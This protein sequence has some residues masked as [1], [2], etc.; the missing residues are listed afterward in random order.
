MCSCRYTCLSVCTWINMF[1]QFPLY[2]LSW[3][4]HAYCASW[5]ENMY[6]H[7]LLN[8][9][10]CVY[11]SR[12]KY[13][14]VLQL[15]TFTFIYSVVTVSASVIIGILSSFS[16]YWVAVRGLSDSGSKSPLSLGVSK[17]CKSS[18]FQVNQFLIPPLA[19][20]FAFLNISSTRIPFYETFLLPF[21]VLHFHQPLETSRI[22]TLAGKQYAPLTIIVGN[23]ILTNG[24]LTND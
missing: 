2:N 24:I 1:V 10:I 21:C 19:D 12:T 14:K 22:S 4:C 11:V 15:K 23:A 17:N 16:S 9:K 13:Y 3:I 18:W 6:S 8:L 20:A 7:L 5:C